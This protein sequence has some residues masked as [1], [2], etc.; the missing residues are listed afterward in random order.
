MPQPDTKKNVK[1]NIPFVKIGL[2]ACVIGIHGKPYV[3][4][5]EM[6][7]VIKVCSRC[8]KVLKVI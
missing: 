5:G 4:C 7:E 6:G 8:G 3:K 2:A 1:A